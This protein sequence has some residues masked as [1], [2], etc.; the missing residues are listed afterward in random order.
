MT[1][2]LYNRIA[3]LII[4]S[5]MTL[6]L[7]GAGISTESGI[8]DFR[9]P[10]TGLWE[11]V[12]PM[13]ALSSDV[14]YNEPHKFYSMGFKILTSM[15]DAKP[16]EAHYKLAQ[17]ERQDLID[18]IITQNIDNLHYEAGSISVYEVHGTI[19]TGHCLRCGLRYNL[20]DI[21]QKVC[22]GEVPPLCPCGGIIRTDVVL[23]GDNLPECFNKAWIKAMKC[24]LMIVIGSSLQVAPVNYLPGLAKKLVIINS[25]ETTYDNK[26]SVICHEKASIALNKIYNAI[27]EI[28]ING[29][30]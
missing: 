21:E 19:K 4:E 18:G 15:K 11:K 27:Q 30:C 9:S 2:E 13:E 3:S 26:A 25:G 6:V 1:T 28:R 24:H 23:F 14:L 5:P 7:T 22:R 8:P 10:G 12:D 16:N 29:K 20:E 17:M